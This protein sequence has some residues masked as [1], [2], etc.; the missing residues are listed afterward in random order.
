MTAKTIGKALMVMGM[1]SVSNFAWAQDKAA[2]STS[3]QSIKETQLV[4]LFS[5]VKALDKT[6]PLT[7]AS[8]KKITKTDLG[9][10]AAD[11]FRSVENPGCNPLVKYVQARGKGSVEL[12]LIRPS[13]VTLSDVKR[14]FGQWHDTG[15]ASSLS[16]GPP[17]R[18]YVYENSKGW[19]SFECDKSKTH[20][21]LVVQLTDK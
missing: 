16:I 1:V 7:H 17:S 21:L 10:Y 18:D 13:A 20:Q 14:V 11:H 15:E 3:D 12:E 2:S 4:A 6:R 19:I 5:L 9:F 8:I